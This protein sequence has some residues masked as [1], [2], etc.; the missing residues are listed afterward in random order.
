MSVLNIGIVG[1]GMIAGVIAKAIQEVETATLAAVASR[2]PES[3]GAF[4]KEHKIPTMFAT[5]EEMVQSDLVDAIY[6]ATPTAVKEEISIA[7]AHGNK[8][9]LVDKPFASLESLERMIT[10]ARENSVAFMDATHFAHHP[11]TLKIKSIMK[12]TIGEPIAVRTCFFFPFL[13]RENI[14]FNVDKE[15]TGAV[16][17][18]AWYSMRAVAEYLAPTAEIRTISGGITRDKKSGAVIK[19]SGLIIFKD[20]KSTTFDFGY[21]AGVCLMDLDILGSEGMF[22]IDDFVLDWKDGFAF[23][24]PDHKV[25]YTKRTGMQEP[26]DF[27]LVEAAAAEPQ[28][29]SM[30]RNFVRYVLEPGSRQE[31]AS[32]RV[33]RQTQSLLDRF[34]QEVGS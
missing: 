6:V 1:S 26:D 5:W 29:N 32:T 34:W 23:D 19:G 16:G 20:D 28:T 14:R 33:T 27:E 30:I 24:N 25:R 10:A 22:H 4:A 17:D 7:A 2:R 3:A 21:N 9:I 31:E 18:M 13:D 12:E 8:H 15:P 11:R